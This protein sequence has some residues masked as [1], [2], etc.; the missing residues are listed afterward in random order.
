MNQNQ[1]NK[2]ISPIGGGKYDNRGGKRSVTKGGYSGEFYGAFGQ[3][4]SGVMISA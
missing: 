3:N 4:R 2:E 1:P